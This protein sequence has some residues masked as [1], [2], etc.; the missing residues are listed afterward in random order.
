MEDNLKLVFHEI[1]KEK[2]EAG[3]CSFDIM[4]NFCPVFKCENGASREREKSYFR[5]PG[6]ASNSEEKGLTMSKK[7]RD[8]WASVNLAVPNSPTLA[9]P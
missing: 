3:K 1:R 5:F 6:V 9:V 2:T 4:V 8:K 7:R